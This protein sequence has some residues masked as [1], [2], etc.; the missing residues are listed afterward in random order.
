MIDNTFIQ[1]PEYQ[2]YLYEKDNISPES[3]VF[4]E[5]KERLI[6]QGKEYQFVPSGGNKGQVLQHTENGLEWQDPTGGTG[7]VTQ[8]DIAN[9]IDDVDYN[10][11]TQEI[12]FYHNGEEITTLDATPFIID[13]FVKEVEIIGTDLVITFNTEDRPAIR[14]SIKEI[15]NP[16]NYYTKEEI[17][18]TYVSKE[19]LAE[20]IYLPIVQ[21]TGD[22]ETSIMSQKAVTEALKN[23]DTPDTDLSDYY[24]KEEID[25]KLNWFEA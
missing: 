16:D 25:T 2:D 9:F 6:T 22:S 7:D 20:S 5:D 17:E 15:F 19:K 11:E 18:E 14:I 3:I 1:S 12:I 13:N 23:L 10:E 8:E 4:V 24:T 21:E